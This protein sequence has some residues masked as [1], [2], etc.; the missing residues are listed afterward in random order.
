[1]NAFVEVTPLVKNQDAQ[2]GVEI[3]VPGTWWV[4]GKPSEGTK[5]FVCTV[6]SYDREYKWAAKWKRNRGAYKISVNDQEEEAYHMS[7]VDFRKFYFQTKS[8]QAVV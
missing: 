6:I 8:A 4:N 1:M 2:E 3:N 7:D 5:V